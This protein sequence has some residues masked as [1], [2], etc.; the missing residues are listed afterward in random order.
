MY[1]AIKQTSHRMLSTSGGASIANDAANDQQ[2]AYDL[3]DRLS[4]YSDNTTSQNLQL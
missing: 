1:L 3:A 2:F 4:A